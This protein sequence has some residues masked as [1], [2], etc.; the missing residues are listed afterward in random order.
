MKI[1][2]PGPVELSPPVIAEI[3]TIDVSTIR[4]ITMK[5]TVMKIPLVPILLW[6]LFNPSL[7]VIIASQ[8]LS[9][10]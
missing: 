8:I 7:Y 4:T 6:N 5:E 9:N 3:L 2:V 10:K 1:A